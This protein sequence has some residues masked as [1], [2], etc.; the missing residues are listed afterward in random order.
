MSTRL[1]Q[2]QL[3]GDRRPC[4]RVVRVELTEAGDRRL[5][6][7]TAL[8]QQLAELLDCA[9]ADVPLVERPGRPAL[10]PGAGYDDVDMSLASNGRVGLV[11]VARG[12]R[13][14]VDVEAIDRN[15]LAQAADEGWLAPVE[16][17]RIAA[18][19]PASQPSALTRAWV[20][21]EAVL[22]ATGVGLWGDMTGTL[23]PAGTEG[24]VSGWLLRPVEV[25]PGY[26]GCLARRRLPLRARMGM[27]RTGR[28]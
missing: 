27:N 15:G 23:T 13:V 22:K 14:G 7:R 19:D 11:A 24:R 1:R 10:H 21:K 5:T 4:L 2:W 28:A 20:Q 26:V 17:A 18:L 8:R 9:A 25:G 6:M 12:Y 3:S 16:R